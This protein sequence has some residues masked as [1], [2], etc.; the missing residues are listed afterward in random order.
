MRPQREIGGAVNWLL[1]LL[2]TA[3]LVASIMI[4]GRAMSRA[5][6]EK[7]QARKEMLEIVTFENRAYSERQEYIGTLDSLQLF[8]DWQTER[9]RVVL[10]SLGGFF[11]TLEHPLEEVDRA[12]EKAAKLR[13]YLQYVE[14]LSTKDRYVAIAD[15]V[16]RFLRYQADIQ[17]GAVEF[18][19]L[20]EEVADALSSDAIEPAEFAKLASKVD[21]LE[22][23]F[24]TDPE[25]VEAHNAYREAL[26]LTR[27]LIPA[28]ERF[29]TSLVDLDTYL[30]SGGRW[31]EAL[32][33]AG[34][35]ADSLR[36]CFLFGGDASANQSLES[37]GNFLAYRADLIERREGYESLFGTVADYLRDESRDPEIAREMSNHTD[38]LKYC[39]LFD[40]PGVLGM[41]IAQTGTDGEEGTE[42]HD[43]PVDLSRISNFLYGMASAWN[44][45]LDSLTEVVPESER[46]AH[47]KAREE[48][49][50]RFASDQ[51][52]K[53]GRA[54]GF[55]EK[56]E[57][58]RG[59]LGGK[60]ENIE[61]D[62]AEHRALIP[63]VRAALEA[64]LAGGAGETVTLAVL[65]ETFESN[66]AGN[67]SRY[68]QLKS[69]IERLDRS[70]FPRSKL[71]TH[72]PAHPQAMYRLEIE[73]DKISVRSFHR[74]DF[75][76]IIEG[77]ATW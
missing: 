22:L 63:D 14:D 47:R 16:Y 27:G 77:D 58:M 38:S 57:L 76:E 34:R 42:V 75:G 44:T 65:R 41:P 69:Q 56:L 45:Q 10:D 2:A 49:K 23:V 61:A 40:T 6:H 18:R 8:L 37:I 72:S 20:F 53:L 19:R 4:P 59:E 36:F 66:L 46:R 30:E 48:L 5:E 17:S 35:R 15:S 32:R 73:G 13:E 51:A 43:R 39:F 52:A 9:Y 54:T 71:S 26:Y 62:L 31:P 24:R 74:D 28:R 1:I 3:G 70:H 60:L 33:L 11:E 29:Q 50:S 25:Q 21:S 55:A 68:T 64:R 7:T 12:A 67:E